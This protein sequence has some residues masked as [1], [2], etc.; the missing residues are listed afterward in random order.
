MCA[1]TYAA[2]TGVVKER[3]AEVVDRA[4]ANVR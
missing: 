4:H 2:A 3:R 1:T